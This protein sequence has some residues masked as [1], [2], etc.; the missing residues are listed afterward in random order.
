[1]KRILCLMLCLIFALSVFGCASVKTDNGLSEDT[2]A[3]TSLLTYDGKGNYTGFENIPDGYSAEQAVE[4]GCLVVDVTSE[5]NGKAKV[6]GSEVWYNFLTKATNGDEATMRVAYFIDGKATYED[7]YYSDGRYTVFANNDNG[8]YK[9]SDF[10]MIRLL[11]KADGT[12][13]FYVLTDSEKLIYED[14][15]PLLANSAAESEID[16]DFLPFTFYIAG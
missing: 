9:K 15:E 1:M 11:E 16:F 4:D 7:L 3:E 6:S 12:D 13:A 10:T 2:E 8:I 5:E 14:A